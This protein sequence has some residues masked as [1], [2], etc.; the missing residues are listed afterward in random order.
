MDIR[1]D[2]KFRAELLR[3]IADREF[4]ERTGVHC[5]DLI[6]CLN[7]QALRRKLNLPSTDNEILLF[8]LG[9]ATQR[10]LTGELE[11][12]P[13]K[14]LDGITVTM[15]SWVGMPWELKCTFQSN[16]K[17]VVE[18][19]AW[20]R[21]IMAQCKVSD[22]LS[23]KLSRLEIMGN[24]KSI[25]GKKEE[26]ALPENQKPTLSAWSCT[27]SHS[28]IEKNWEWMIS[29][30]KIFEGLLEGSP[31]VVPMLALPPKQEW[32]CGYC[33]FKGEECPGV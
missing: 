33:K 8:S 15:D 25:F 24:W 18:N 7:K 21:Q 29:R 19:T 13:E 30:K 26:K 6:Y 9:W 16:Q 23:A 14:E 5:S 22:K 17:P 10:W 20:V 27:F 32:E 11:D 4:S 2:P 31:L 12:E 3:K 1:E 28:E